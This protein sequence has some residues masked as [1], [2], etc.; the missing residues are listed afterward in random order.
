[1]GI[2]TRMEMAA[3]IEIVKGKPRLCGHLQRS[4]YGMTIEETGKH[5]S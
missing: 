4:V 1:M 5:T 3:I 2:G